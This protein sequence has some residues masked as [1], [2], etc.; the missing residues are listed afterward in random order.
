M[1]DELEAMRRSRVSLDSSTLGWTDLLNPAECETTQGETNQCETILGSSILSG[2]RIPLTE[3]A[4]RVYEL[5]D[6]RSRLRVAAVPEAD[7]AIDWLIT[8]GW[9]AVKATPSARP[10]T[11]SSE[12]EF[13]EPE[14]ESSEPDTAS[15]RL[16][17]PPFGIEQAAGLEP[18][19]AVCI[20][21]GSGR[22]AVWLADRGWQVTAI[23]ILPDG[24]ER[25]RK[26]EQKYAAKAA[27]KIEWRLGEWE[28]IGEM[29]PRSCQLVTSFMFMADR[30]PG[31]MNR[32]LS[33]GGLGLF[34]CRTATARE[35]T[36][37]PKRRE[38]AYPPADSS[39]DPSQTAFAITFR[40]TG[41]LGV[42]SWQSPAD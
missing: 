36:G 29:E 20:A 11:M 34:S 37:H 13:S 1:S 31:Q 27:F 32:L 12:S 24:L 41:D 7:A 2:C 23:D 25:A 28:T 30:L 18:G 5:P 40:E 14:S 26:L 16:W 8:K 17:S 39:A 3:L 4:G 15:L 42:G 9:D 6:K 38:R 35:R 22:E 21:C 33:P 10:E 19:R